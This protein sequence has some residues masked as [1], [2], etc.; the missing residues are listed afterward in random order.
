[1]RGRGCLEKDLF[2]RKRKKKQF[3]TFKAGEEHSAR[4]SE[5][6]KGEIYR[7]KSSRFN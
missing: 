5:E 6:V 7:I 2:V 3:E 4:G 1:M